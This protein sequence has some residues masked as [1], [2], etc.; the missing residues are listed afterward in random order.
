[1]SARF[2]FLAG[3]AW[4]CICGACTTEPV[5]SPRKVTIGAL[6]PLTGDLSSLGQASEA[7]L[8]LAV[9]E[10]NDYYEQLGLPA[11][12]TLVVED[13]H[14]D[15]EQALDKLRSF[16][17]QGI[18]LGIGPLTDEGFARCLPYAERTNRLLV[19]PFST[20]P[21]LAAADDNGFR[22]VPDDAIWVQAMA[23]AMH[24]DGIDAIAIMHRSGTGADE[25][26]Q[27]VASAF[28]DTGGSIIGNITYD[29][30][31]VPGTDFRDELD[32]LEQLVSDA[33]NDFG[34]AGVA[35]QLVSFDEAI[36]IFKQADSRSTLS[37]VRWYGAAGLAVNG[38][39]IIDDEAADF[40]NR[41]ALVA[42]AYG[43]RDPE[44]YDV[45][46]AALEEE[47]GRRPEPDAIVAY[48]ALWLS[49][50][51][52]FSSPELANADTLRAALPNAAGI[53]QPATGPIELNA[54]GDRTDGPI[55]FWQVTTAGEQ[56]VWRRIATYA[57]GELQAIDVSTSGL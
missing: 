17:G 31:T 37:A 20:A 55:E 39:L 52:A 10:V 22:L 7:A 8:A 56:F 38:D 54:A 51:A 9:V 24:Q 33:T 42:P 48:D 3:A 21:S 36:Q 41:V 25:L 47:L 43:G 40:A 32:E 57:D 12:L 30:S 4:M 14:A 1:M 5:V 44:R 49:A 34:T 15:A 16:S 2:A 46:E 50:L 26:T 11:E 13:T 23:D 19:S 29:P 6:L 18:I 35:V 53:Y 28:A 27:S 45:V